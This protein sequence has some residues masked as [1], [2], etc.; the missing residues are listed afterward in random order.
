MTA[1]ST[2][3]PLGPG[4]W[5]I[6]TSG[7][8]V[9][10]YCGETETRWSAEPKAAAWLVLGHIR[11]TGI[12]AL[13]VGPAGELVVLAETETLLGQPAGYLPHLCT[14]IPAE[15]HEQYADEIAARAGEAS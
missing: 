3:A 12:H 6:H 1:D 2:D 5:E 11:L 13:G 15:V 14:R 9:C 7:A 4:E 10:G 8:M